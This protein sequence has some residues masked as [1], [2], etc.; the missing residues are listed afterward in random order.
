M[1]GLSYSIY[2]IPCGMTPNSIPDVFTIE[3][4]LH[5]I[6]KGVMLNSNISSTLLD[7]E[8]YLPPS[9]LFPCQLL[10]FTTYLLNDEIGAFAFRMR[11]ETSKIQV[12]SFV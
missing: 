6:K 12:Y 9:S 8:L 7:S 3:K 1:N 2:D 4:K 5:R 10:T 11:D